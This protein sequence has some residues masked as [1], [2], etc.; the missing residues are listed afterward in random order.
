MYKYTAMCSDN[1]RTWSNGNKCAVAIGNKEEESHRHHNQQRSSSPV[2]SVVEAQEQEKGTIETGVLV[3][4]ASGWGGAGWGGQ[5]RDLLGLRVIYIFIWAVGVSTC[6]NIH[7]Q[8]EIP[9][10]GV[11][12]RSRKNIWGHNGWKPNKSSQKKKRKETPC[13]RSLMNSK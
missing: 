3:E 10:T 5:Q 1:R 9:E 11:W 7:W 13:L 12:K 4:A 8:D 6:V 2:V